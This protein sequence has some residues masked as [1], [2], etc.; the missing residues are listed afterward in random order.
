MSSTWWRQTLSFHER[1]LGRA[2]RLARHEAGPHILMLHLSS[3]NEALSGS[4]PNCLHTGA[5]TSHKKNWV[6]MLLSTR[7]ECRECHRAGLCDCRLAV[8]GPFGATL[9]DVFHYP[10]SVCIAAGI[11]VTPFAALLKSVWYKCCE[12][13]TLPKLSKVWEKIITSPF[14]G[15]KGSVSFYLSSANS[16][17]GF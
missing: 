11:G 12:S 16:W 6:R 7:A 9:T 5:N 15:L 14:R 8:D 2:V 4:E 3:P 1:H 17:G 13:Q 10:V